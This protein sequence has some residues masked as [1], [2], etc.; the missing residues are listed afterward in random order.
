MAAL[1]PLPWGVITGACLLGAIILGAAITQ[2][3]TDLAWHLLRLA[4]TALAA[5]AAFVLDE[6]AAAAV[7]ATP[8]S[9][10]RHTAQRLLGTLVPATVWLAGVA[11][12]E[13]RNQATPAA[14]LLLEGVGALSLA[15]AVAACLRRAGWAT[16]GETASTAVAVTLVALT[17]FDP[18]PGTVPVFPT[19]T[20]W[21]AS[22]LL[23]LAITAAAS[24]TI[25][26]ASRQQRR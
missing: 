25:V 13:H 7:D 14:G 15:V 16:P 24:A 5:A 26:V 6:A 19:V 3:G 2:P 18:F 20:H 17:A 9:R 1:G 10:S 22:G 11:V 8:R 4:L 21:H 12:L 23:W